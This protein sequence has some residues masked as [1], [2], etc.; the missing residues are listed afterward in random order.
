MSI[1]KA[2]E[3]FNLKCLES[4]GLSKLF[5]VNAKGLQDLHV[6]YCQQHIELVIANAMGLLKLIL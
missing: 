6:S 4:R 5:I 2:I 1:E 3:V